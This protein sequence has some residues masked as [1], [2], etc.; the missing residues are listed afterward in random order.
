MGGRARESDEVVYSPV[1]RREM[2]SGFSGQLLEEAG[3]VVVIAG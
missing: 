2:D 1:E 3:F